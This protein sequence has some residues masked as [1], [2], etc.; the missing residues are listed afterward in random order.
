MWADV[1]KGIIRSNEAEALSAKTQLENKQRQE[2][3]QRQ[4]HNIPWVPKRFV[5]KA[6]E[7][8]YEWK[9]WEYVVVRVLNIG[10]KLMT[11][12]EIKK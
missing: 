3:Q 12:Y 7:E 9:D 1:I 2:E 8:C 5:K 11:E 6:N 10:S 4:A